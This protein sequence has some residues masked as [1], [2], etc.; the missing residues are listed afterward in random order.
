MAGKTS[1]KSNAKVYHTVKILSRILALTAKP[2]N[3]QE[4]LSTQKTDVKSASPQKPLELRMG[5]NLTVMAAEGEGKGP[6]VRSQDEQKLPRFQP[7]S[8]TLETGSGCL[9]LAKGGK[10]FSK[11]RSRPEYNPREGRPAL[12]EKAFP[13]EFPGLREK[14]FLNPITHAP[15]LQKKGKQR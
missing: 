4:R 6:G 7:R 2:L 13:C 14:P 11:R 5:E 12:Q 8:F 9:L 15:G 10:T 1:R 3:K